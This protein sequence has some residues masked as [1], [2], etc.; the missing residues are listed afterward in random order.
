MEGRGGSGYSGVVF[1]AIGILP[2]LLYLG[3]PERNATRDIEKE[4]GAEESDE[5]ERLLSKSMSLDSEKSLIQIRK[6]ASKSSPT[7]TLDSTNHAQTRSRSTLRRMSGKQKVVQSPHQ[8]QSILKASM[9]L[10]HQ[11]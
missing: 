3:A 2:T 5:R 1:V 6:A 10:H 11:H 7:F 9:K 4:D 8:C